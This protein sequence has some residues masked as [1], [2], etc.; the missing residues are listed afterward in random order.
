ME[1][2]NIESDES[3]RLDLSSRPLSSD[4][5]PSGEEITPWFYRGKKKSFRMRLSEEKQIF[6]SKRLNEKEI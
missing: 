1:A 3:G 4:L 6:E 2:G 5:V